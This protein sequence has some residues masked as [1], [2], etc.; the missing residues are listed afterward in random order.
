[1]ALQYRTPSD[2]DVFLIDAKTGVRGKIL[3]KD[4]APAAGYAGFAWSLDNQRLFLTT[5]QRGEFSELAVFDRRDKSLTVLSSHIPWDSES[6]SLSAD[7][8]RLMTVA[9]NN[10]VDELHMFDASNKQD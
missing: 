6:F 4:N 3:P 2:S 5:N 9:N 1:M 8:R 10:G 7:G